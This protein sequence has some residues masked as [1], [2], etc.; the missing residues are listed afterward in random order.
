MPDLLGV[1]IGRAGPA[2]LV[3][4]H[5]PGPGGKI[6]FAEGM[7]GIL[8][9]DEG[10]NVGQFRSGEINLFAKG[11][12]LG[13]DHGRRIVPHPGREI[14]RMNQTHPVMGV[15]VGGIMTANPVDRVAGDAALFDE[16]FLPR[17]G[18]MIGMTNWAAAPFLMLVLPVT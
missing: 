1:G 14:E 17:S 6:L 9:M 4:H 7:L 3:L 11:T 5:L 2:M 8:V 10:D 16:D 15:H 18:F 13:R 12:C